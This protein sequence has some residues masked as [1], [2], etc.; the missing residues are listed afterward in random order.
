MQPA[1]RRRVSGHLHLKETLHS[2]F[3]LPLA[4]FLPP[5][6][7]SYQKSPP[8]GALER[9]VGDL[10][11]S[12][13]GPDESAAVSFEEVP[14][15]GSIGGELVHQPSR[16]GLPRESIVGN[17]LSVEHEWDDTCDL[18]IRDGLIE[19]RLSLVQQLAR[20]ELFMNEAA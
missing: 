16:V 9:L 7:L 11:L 14:L 5:V 19:T 18:Q 17:G 8:S 6:S 2:N 13:D 3:C 4:F 1:E 10:E 15:D 20:L 12:E